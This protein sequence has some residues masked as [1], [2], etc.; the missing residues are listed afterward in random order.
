MCNI[1]NFSISIY[2][3]RRRRLRCTIV[4]LCDI[5]MIFKAT[6]TLTQFLWVLSTFGQTSEECCLCYVKIARAV[7]VR[8]HL[9]S[10]FY[11]CHLFFLMQLMK[12]L[13]FLWLKSHFMIFNDRIKRKLLFCLSV[14]RFLL[15]SNKQIWFIFMRKEHFMNIQLILLD[16]SLSLLLHRRRSFQ[17][18]YPFTQ[19]ERKMM[20]FSLLFRSR[21]LLSQTQCQVYW[22]IFQCCSNV[23]TNVSF[24]T[25]W[26][27][28]QY[29]MRKA[30]LMNN[31]E[32]LIHIIPSQLQY[33][34]HS[35]SST[36]REMSMY[37]T[38]CRIA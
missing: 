14:I 6:S 20:K 16:M 9:L 11:I 37:I 34:L 15:L 2:G 17:S 31:F 3:Y 28:T 38:S 29:I 13:S 21:V 30:S 22:K 27:L 5:C 36:P 33:L 18:L 8:I 19:H 1:N 26:T 4:D 35:C 10:I 7:R 25:G 32:K 12:I 24:H 23:S